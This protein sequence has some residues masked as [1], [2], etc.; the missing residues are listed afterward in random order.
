MRQDRTVR[1]GY[2]QN[3]RLRRLAPCWYSRYHLRR[4]PCIDRALVV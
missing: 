1:S 2:D 4:A 3:A